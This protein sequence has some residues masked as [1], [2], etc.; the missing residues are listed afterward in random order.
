MNIDY[1]EKLKYFYFAHYKCGPAPGKIAG[2]DKLE[3]YTRY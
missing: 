2:P 1:Y 3:K